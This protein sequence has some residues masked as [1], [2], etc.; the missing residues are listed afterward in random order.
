MSLDGLVKGISA[1]FFNVTGDDGPNT[2]L[3]QIAPEAEATVTFVND[4]TDRV[5]S[6]LPRSTRLTALSGNHWRTIR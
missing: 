4:Q 2:L 5:K 1:I 6:D 3:A